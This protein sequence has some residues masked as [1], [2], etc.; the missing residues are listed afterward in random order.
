MS[1]HVS[2]QK[3]T[4]DQVAEILQSS[5][6]AT[7]LAARFGVT[8]GAISPIRKRLSHRAIKAALALGLIPPA[9]PR[10][11]WKE[12]ANGV[13]TVPANVAA[14]RATGIGRRRRVRA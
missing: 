2:R 4:D 8:T 14:A 1:E 6:P 3:L 7:E 5:A 11:V 13:A 10:G 12:G 9:P